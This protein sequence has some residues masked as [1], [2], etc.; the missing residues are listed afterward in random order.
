MKMIEQDMTEICDY[1]LLHKYECSH[2]L[3]TDDSDIT[4]DHDYE[5]V[6][7][8]PSQFGGYCNLVDVHKIRKGDKV[9]KIRLADNPMVS[10]PG[11][12][13]TICALDIPRAK[14]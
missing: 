10:I 12:A 8:F 13:C 1:S 6:A 3:G 7:Y 2:C 4:P 5:I 11:V 14:S 9:A